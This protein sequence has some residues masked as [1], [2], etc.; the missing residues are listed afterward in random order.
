MGGKYL[1]GSACQWRGL[2]VSPRRIHLTGQGAARMA[3]V[4]R[5]WWPKQWRGSGRENR[6]STVLEANAVQ[7]EAGLAIV[8]V[9]ILS[10]AWANYWVCWRFRRVIAPPT[11]ACLYRMG[12]R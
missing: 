12:C 2:G 7:Q 6:M 8:F 3:R 11:D 9:E 4:L 5:L 1:L 10:D